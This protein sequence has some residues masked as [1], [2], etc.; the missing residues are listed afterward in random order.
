VSL[1]P[2]TVSA[3]RLRGASLRLD[4]WIPC[5][6]GM[7]RQHSE[8]AVGI[9]LCHGD[10]CGTMSLLGLSSAAWYEERRVQ[11]PQPLFRRRPPLRLQL[12]FFLAPKAVFPRDVQAAALPH[13][14]T[15]CAGLVLI[16]QQTT[17]ADRYSSGTRGHRSRG[18]STDC[19]MIDGCWLRDI[20]MVFV[21]P[22]V[23]M[24]ANASVH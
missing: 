1:A 23:F 15:V 8:D 12:P 9:A 16:T 2:C 11:L 5:C 6:R 4:G 22:G 17:P 13:F 18:D 7:H 14:G 19:F 10:M 3:F 24:V 20:L 21:L